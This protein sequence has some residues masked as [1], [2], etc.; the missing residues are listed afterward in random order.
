VV[1]AAVLQ[2]M[3]T[4]ADPRAL[5]R[6]RRKA[7]R[8]ALPVQ[9]DRGFAQELPYPDA[10]FDRVLSAFMFHHLGPDEKE[11]TLGEVRER[12][13]REAMAIVG[14]RDIRLL[15]FRDSGMAGTEE[16]RDPRAF[17]NADVD[18]VVTALVQIIDELKP[19]VVTTFGPDGIYGHPDHVMAH[20]VATMAVLRAGETGI[21]QVPALYYAAASRERIQR[22]AALP[23]SPFHSMPPEALATFGTP[24]AEISTKLDV[25]AQV[26]R[27]RAAIRAH[28]TQI[29]D[30]G[31]WAGL[32][33][34]EVEQFTQTESLRLVPLP[35]NPTPEDLLVQLTQG[36]VRRQAASPS[37]PVAV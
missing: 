24:D 31:P 36:H 3:L 6:A 28:R 13:L 33:E 37:D 17:V 7:G 29:G 12:E 15:G 26:E 4:H 27:K 8:K 16:N 11:E 30:D 35:W 18:A 20:R 34:A 22:F 1:D 5:A 9:L 19:T 23:R 14:V 21:W 32:P 10:S 2:A 25:S